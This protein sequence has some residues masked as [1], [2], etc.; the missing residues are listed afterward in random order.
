M[1]SLTSY[2]CEIIFKKG[3]N[4]VAEVSTFVWKK[5]EEKGDF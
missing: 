4:K 3:F 5:L 1:N 2:H